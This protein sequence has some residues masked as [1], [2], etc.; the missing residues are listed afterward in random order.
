[1]YLCCSGTNFAL[2]EVFCEKNPGHNLTWGG[3]EAE[4]G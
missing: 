1:M 2:S 3:G 4:Q